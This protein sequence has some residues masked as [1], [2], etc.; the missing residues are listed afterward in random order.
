MNT[1]A[2]RTWAARL[3]A[4][5]LPVTMTGCVSAAGATA[6]P[7]AQPT[8]T[9]PAL[10]SAASPAVAQDMWSNGVV[11]PAGQR[12]AIVEGGV[13]W[14]VSEQYETR[15][16]ILSKLALQDGTAATSVIVSNLQ[17]YAGAGLAADGQGGL[18]VAFASQVVRV[19]E[20]TGALTSWSVPNATGDVVAAQGDPGGGAIT[21]AAWDGANGELLFVRNEN[22]RLYAFNPVTGTSAVRSELSVVTSSSSSLV[23]AA[24][25]DIGVTGSASATSYMPTAALLGPTGTSIS[26]SGVTQLCRAP[27][28][29]ATLSSS[30]VVSLARSGATNGVGAV[31][32]PSPGQ[33][34][35]AC[36]AQGNVFEAVE[37]SGKVVVTRLSAT[38]TVSTA[39]GSLV[40]ITVHGVAGTAPAYADPGLSALL[41]DGSGGAWLASQIGTSSAVPSP[42]PYPSLAHVR[43]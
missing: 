28:G 6:L 39:S 24:S 34:P 41:P 11:L 35:F 31:A 22:H 19:D 38:G 8:D 18:W 33:V 21:A 5:L 10:A 37:S 7:A 32:A 40:S 20:A 29:L 26:L 3:L 42:L 2:R 36:D 1:F 13:G 12:T 15:S 4:A 16:L 27:S 43:F 25:G 9:A 17:S 14:I 30:G 23:V